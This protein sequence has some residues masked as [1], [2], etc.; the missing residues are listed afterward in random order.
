MKAF[1][2]K[3]KEWP[4]LGDVYIVNRIPIYYLLEEVSNSIYVFA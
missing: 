2:L 3:H 4:F 1:V